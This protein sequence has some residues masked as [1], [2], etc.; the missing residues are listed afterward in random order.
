[1]NSNSVPRRS[2][3]QRFRILAVLVAMTPFLLVEITVR[4]CG[5]GLPQESYDPYLGF[6]SVEPLF[7]LNQD[8]QRYQVSESRLDFFRPE[9]FSDHKVPGTYRIFCL[10]GSTVQ[11]RPYSLE[12]A[13]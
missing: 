9:Q 7:V 8:Q 2:R 13:C 6:E 5:W 1:M 12:T 11:G 10:G 4:L 3:L